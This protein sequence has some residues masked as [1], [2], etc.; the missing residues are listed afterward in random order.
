MLTNVFLAVSK[1]RYRC[2]LYY[3]IHNSCCCFSVYSCLSV[4]LCSDSSWYF[5][6]SFFF[7]FFFNEK[8]IS[9]FH[10]PGSKI[11]TQVPYTN[12]NIV[13]LH[14]LSLLQSSGALS[15]F[16]H[17]CKLRSGKKP[18]HIPSFRVLED[19]DVEVEEEDDEDD[20]RKT[21]N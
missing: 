12:S 9:S 21:R 8:A 2:T 20:V 17:R 14:K 11:L 3:Y 7:Y 1:I 16:R 6:S 5:F 4:T 10:V 18:P 19:E 15:R 13:D